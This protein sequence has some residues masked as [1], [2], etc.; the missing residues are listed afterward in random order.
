MTSMRAKL[1][2]TN[3]EVHG[4]TQETLH[5][6]AVCKE[7]AYDES[8]LDENN[9]YS[10]FTPAADLKMIITNPSLLGKFEIGQNYY[11]DFTEADS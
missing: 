4:D 6:R 1:Q 9:T 5:F 8:G 3:V 7:D 2:I 10:K 11:V